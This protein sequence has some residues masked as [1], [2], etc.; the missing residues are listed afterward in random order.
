M[1]RCNMNMEAKLVL[2]LE[3]ILAEVR[4]AQRAGDLGRLV[5]LSYFQLRRW[6]RATGNQILATRASELFLNC[7]F[8]SR[9][10]L[11]AGLSGLVD[12]AERAGAR[13]AAEREPSVLQG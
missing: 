9:E 8:R 5:L 1:L 12:E 11:L 6:A 7:P 3:D 4:A 2:E 10:D 13:Y